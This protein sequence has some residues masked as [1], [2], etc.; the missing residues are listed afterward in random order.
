MG[1]A[2]LSFAPLLA[3]L[4]KGPVQRH[5]GLESHLLG[6]PW[7]LDSFALP[8]LAAGWL[9]S[10]F[11]FLVCCLVFFCS[12]C[13]PFLKKARGFRGRLCFYLKKENVGERPPSQKIGAGHSSSVGQK[14]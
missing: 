5:G 3:L 4:R 1:C 11:T 12:V 8:W 9:V 14:E 2:F 10:G 7:P 6:A 13:A